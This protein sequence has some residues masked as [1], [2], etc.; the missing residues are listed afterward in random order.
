MP[1][2]VDTVVQL[3][4]E[5]DLEDAVDWGMLNIDEDSAARLL[6]TS[7]VE[8]YESAIRPMP[9]ADRDYV[10][11]AAISKLTIENFVLHLKLAQA[12]AGPGV[13]KDETH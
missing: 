4:K 1:L 10:I 9:E 2:D 5:M 12:N 8:H 7:V 11:V 3:I 13:P 6:A